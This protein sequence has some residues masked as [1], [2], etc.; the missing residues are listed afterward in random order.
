LTAL[1]PVIRGHQSKLS[2]LASTSTN[3]GVESRRVSITNATPGGSG[4]GA[5]LA[6]TLAARNVSVVVLTKDPPKCETQNGESAAGDHGR[7]V[8]RDG[9]RGDAQ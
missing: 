2:T 5:L 7:R 6:E 9:R 3:F 8:M 1:L 4:I